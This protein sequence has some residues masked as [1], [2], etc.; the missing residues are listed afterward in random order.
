MN[1]TSIATSK[2]AKLSAAMQSNPNANKT[3]TWLCARCAYHTSVTLGELVRIA[4]AKN[5]AMRQAVEVPLNRVVRQRALWAK[6]RMTFFAPGVD[7]DAL[8]EAPALAQ[9]ERLAYPCRCRC[10]QTNPPSTM[11]VASKQPQ[12]PSRCMVVTPI[13]KHPLANTAQAH[14]SVVNQRPH[15]SQ[16]HFRP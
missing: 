7:S 11:P 15:F 5:Q 6:L 1:Y 12:Q 16:R 9:H 14:G 13:K 10:R 4:H 2:R 3:P 8:A